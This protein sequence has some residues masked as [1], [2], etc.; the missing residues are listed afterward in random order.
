MLNN[1]QAGI[2]KPHGR[3]HVR[4]IFV[5]FHGSRE[6]VANWIKTLDITS[7][8]SQREDSKKRR[9]AKKGGLYHK[10]QLI[11]NCFFSP[12]G[13]GYLGYGKPSIVKNAL[14]LK[15]VIPPDESSSFWDGMDKCKDLNDPPQVKWEY[16]YQLRYHALLTIS[17]NDINSLNTVQGDLTYSLEATSIG[18]VA[19]VEY[20]KQ[21]FNEKQ[22][23]IEPFGYRDGIT[24]TKFFDETGELIKSQ[25]PLVLLG[26]GGVDCDSILVFR[27][28]KQDVNGFKESIINLANK[29]AKERKNQNLPKLKK[30]EMIRFV[31]GQVMGRYKDGRPITLFDINEK[32]TATEKSDSF[33]N[34]SV[35]RRS[36]GKN[37]FGMNGFDYRDDNG[38]KC[39]LHAHIRI[40]NPRNNEL[41]QSSVNPS[42]IIRRSIPYQY[43]SDNQGLLFM[44]FQKDLHQQFITI[45]AS[46]ANQNFYSKSNPVEHGVDPVIGQENIKIQAKK[47]E[48]NINYGKEGKVSLNFDKHVSFQGGEFFYVPAISF[49][50][51][52]LDDNNCKNK[53]PYLTKKNPNIKKT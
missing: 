45:Q 3:N 41:G 22:E 52:P 34:F 30:K 25:L 42:V 16:N 21:L 36:K 35:I 5:R 47:Q 51:N 46:W 23:P 44:C 48:W 9:A 13:L 50:A 29:I 2:L 38:S 28:L 26:E 17:G 4:C 6:E 18:K 8:A 20:G 7:A 19:F 39:P 43:S 49:F 53:I 24:R 31:E 27:K 37:M 14:A 32:K 10:E 15:T 40:T 33:D 1:I 12:M 11:V